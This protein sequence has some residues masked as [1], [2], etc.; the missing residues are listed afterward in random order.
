[1]HGVPATQTTGDRRLVENVQNDG[2]RLE[3]GGQRH[4]NAAWATHSCVCAGRERGGGGREGAGRRT[5]SKHVK[6]VPWDS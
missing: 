3:H 4:G 5:S 1:V 2:A 6:E